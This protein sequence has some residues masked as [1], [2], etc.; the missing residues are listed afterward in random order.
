MPALVVQELIKARIGACNLVAA[1]MQAVRQVE[2]PPALRLPASYVT[3][4][5]FG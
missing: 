4:A 5:L 3:L 1:R 2:A